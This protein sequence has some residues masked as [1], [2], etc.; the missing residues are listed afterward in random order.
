MESKDANVS[1][2]IDTSVFLKQTC[3]LRPW[4]EKN[5]ICGRPIWICCGFPNGSAFVSCLIR[6]SVYKN[7]PHKTYFSLDHYVAISFWEHKSPLMQKSLFLFFSCASFSYSLFLRE[8]R[9]QSLDA[10]AENA[11]VTQSQRSVL[12]F[13][14]RIMEMEVWETII[15]CREKTAI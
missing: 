10:Y 12:H 9:R 15:W 3:D 1:W 4:E 14:R 8:K 6:F 7:C 5:C 11:S 13:S 2:K